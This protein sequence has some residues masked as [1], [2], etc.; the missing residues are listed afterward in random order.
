M[1]AAWAR[2]PIRE[3]YGS[4]VFRLGEGVA[5]LVARDRVPA[6][7]ND[8]PAHRGFVRARQPGL[9]PAVRA[10]RSTSTRSAR[11]PCSSAC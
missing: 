5:G 3:T 9:A 6:L 2:D 4:P 8:V 7:V 1:F 11:T 10:A